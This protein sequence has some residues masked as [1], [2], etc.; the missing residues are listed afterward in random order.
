M[1]A[2]NHDQVNAYDFACDS[3]GDDI[4]ITRRSA[5]DEL[6]FT[7]LAQ[8]ADLVTIN[9]GLLIILA[10][11]RRIH[12]RNQPLDRLVVLALQKQL[13]AVRVLGVVCSA[14]Q[15]N[16]RR[17]ATTDLI[18]Q[19]GTRAIV[20]HAVGARAQPEYLLQQLHAFAYR[21]GIGKRTEIAMPR[22]E[23]AAVKCQARKR[24][25]GQDDIWVRFIV[26]KQYVI[27]RS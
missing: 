20:E 25:S 1:T 2:A 17:G 26:S 14:H 16:A 23:A 8:S 10:L 3:A 13:G 27:A 12:A 21:A 24:V 7:H 19:T 9:R 15:T 11:G 4:G 6:L 18:Q 22:V 5:G